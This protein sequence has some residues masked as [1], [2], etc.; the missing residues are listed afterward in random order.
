MLPNI[1][2]KRL[3]GSVENLQ[4]YAGK[5]LLIV[6]VASNCGFTSQYRDLQNLYTANQAKGLEILGFPCNQFGAQEPGSAEQIQSFC[7]TNYGVTFPMFEKIDVNGD[8][9]HPLYA[10]LKD[11][12]PGILG[13]TGIKWNFTKFLVSKD[14]QSITRLASAD[15]ASKMEEALQKLL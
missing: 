15:G 7:S 9:T 4:D 14:G 10:Y 12:A 8:N 5:V 13:T 3:D 1:P 2:L 6:N 11:R